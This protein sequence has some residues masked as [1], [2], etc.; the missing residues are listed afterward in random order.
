[1]EVDVEVHDVEEHVITDATVGVL[2]AVVGL[3]RRWQHA[4]GKGLMERVLPALVPD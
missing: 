3:A 1:M 2:P 4:V